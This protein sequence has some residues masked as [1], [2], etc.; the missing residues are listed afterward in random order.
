MKRSERHKQKLKRII[1]NV[2]SEKGVNQANKMY[3]ACSR[4]L[5]NVSMVLLKTLTTSR[6]LTEEMKTVVYSQ[7]T[8]IINLEVRRCGL[9]VIT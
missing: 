4:N 1:D 3:A 7:V 5:F 6:N 8:Q 2:L 9:S